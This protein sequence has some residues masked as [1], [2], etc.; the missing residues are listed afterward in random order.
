MTQKTDTFDLDCSILSDTVHKQQG[1]T[2]YAHTIAT[3][4]ASA[5][6]RIEGRIPKDHWTIVSEITEKH[7]FNG[8]N[9]SLVLEDECKKR[10]L[11]FEKVKTI[12]EAKDWIQK[13]HALTANFIIAETQWQNLRQFLKREPHN[14]M[15]MNHLGESDAASGKLHNHAVV[16]GG[17]DEKKKCWIIK[18]SW[19]KDSGYHGYWRV[20]VDHGLTFKFCHVYFELEDLTDDDLLS[21]VIKYGFNEEINSELHKR[22]KIKEFEERYCDLLNQKMLNKLCHIFK[23]LQTCIHAVTDPVDSGKKQSKENRKNLKLRKLFSY[24]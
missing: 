8:K 6:R 3:V 7:G 10:Q 24:K 21:Y 4:L 16:I 11:R 9:I 13:R 2:C 18:N 15:T 14:V 20:S 22:G 17:Y 12:E 1:G 23:L 5:E 19:G